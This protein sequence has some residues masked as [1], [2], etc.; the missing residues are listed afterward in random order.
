MLTPHFTDP[1]D[2]FRHIAA[3]PTASAAIDMYVGR[4]F[5]LA[6]KAAR[7]LAGDLL[8]ASAGLG[9]VEATTPIPLYEA[10]VSGQSSVAAHFAFSP[11]DWWS[12]LLSKS[13]YSTHWPPPEQTILVAA[14]GP[15]LEMIQSNLL[16][17]P[18][19]NLRIFCRVKPVAMPAELRPALMPYDARFDGP[20]SPLPGTIADFASRALLHFAEAVWSNTPLGSLREHRQRVEKFANGWSASK[21]RSG[22]SV[23]DAEVIELIERHAPRVGG[24]STAMLRLLRDDLGVACEQKRFQKLFRTAK[25]WSGGGLCLPL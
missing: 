4:A 25:I 9:L 11:Q 14:S 17:H 7:N 6:C 18:V 5:Q 12:E 13:P 16:I 10:T 22:R 19:E 8:I 24:R 20:E 15:Y 1:S 3:A 2:W 21:R 23:S